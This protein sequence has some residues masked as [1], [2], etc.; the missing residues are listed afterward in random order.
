MRPQRLSGTLKRRHGNKSEAAVV[1]LNHATVEEPVYGPTLAFSLLEVWFRRQASSECRC[2]K[3]PGATQLIYDIIVQKTT[4]GSH[5]PSVDSSL[6]HCPGISRVS[7]DVT[8]WMWVMRSDNL[9]IRDCFKLNHGSFFC[10][11]IYCDL[12]RPADERAC[13]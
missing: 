9:I 5:W 2:H 13:V 6:G 4:Q 12:W 11:F 10:F 7:T 8:T 3:R 1:T